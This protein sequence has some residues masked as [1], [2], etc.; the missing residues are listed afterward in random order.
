MRQFAYRP[1]R[2]LEDATVTLLN[3][4][5]RHLDGKGTSAR[6]L[7]VDLTSSFNTIQPHVLTRRLLKQ[8]DLSNNLVGWILDFLTKRTQ[9]VRVYGV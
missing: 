3:G 2:G 5:L 1:H 6:L 4:L 7:F 9:I 8:F